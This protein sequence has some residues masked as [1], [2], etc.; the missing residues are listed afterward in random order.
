MS[1]ANPY[2]ARL[3]KARRRLEGI[4]TSDLK[5]AQSALWSVILDSYERM[6]REPSNQEFVR[7]AKTLIS[8]IREYRSALETG[9]LEA[10]ISILEADSCI[11]TRS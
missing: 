5:I 10:R 11:P 2:K 9:E 6:I 3:E 4:K 1:N 8:A 7:L